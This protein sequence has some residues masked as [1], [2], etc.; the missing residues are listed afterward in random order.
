MWYLF[1]ITSKKSS[2]FFLLI[3]LVRDYCFIMPTTTKPVKVYFQCNP[4][5]DI[6][7]TVK[8]DFLKPY[9]LGI[10]EAGLAKEEQLSIFP[11]LEKCPD[12]EYI[13]GGAGLNSA[14]VCQWLVQNKAQTVF[15]GCIGKDHYGQRLK[16][17]AEKD[18]VE[19]LVE[20][21]DKAPTGTCAV[22]VVGKERTLL[23]NLAASNLLSTEH[24]HSAAVEKI[25]EECSIFYCT[26]YALILDVAYVLQ[27]AE[28]AH[29]VPGGLFALNISAPYIVECFTES[30]LKVLPHV[31]ILFGNENEARVLAKKM[32][33][34]EQEDVAKIAELLVAKLSHVEESSHDVVVV[35]TQGANDSVYASKKAF[36]TAVRVPIKPVPAEKVVDTNGA[37]D[38]FVGGFLAA[39]SQG[40]DMTRCVETGSYA[41][42]VIIQSGGC[43]LPPFPDP[44]YV[45]S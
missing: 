1:G 43:S 39:R 36:P 19:M 30:F 17:A 25:L 5:L 45:P 28:A 13:P 3:P 18:G 32:Q 8:E 21:T 22:A 38:S 20:Q 34:E 24:M 31:D 2:S 27:V 42:S 37:G 12:V 41:A 10:G 7:A 15:V 14:R 29:K 16:D 9:G 11:E 44:Q 4:L 33:L 40:K 23:A 6:S 26:G 35:F